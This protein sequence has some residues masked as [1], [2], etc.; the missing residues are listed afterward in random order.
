MACAAVLKWRLT[1]YTIQAETPLS[2][3][4]ATQRM[5]LWS[6]SR[7]I[8]CN[9]FHV[10]SIYD[11]FLELLQQQH[12]TFELIHIIDEVIDSIIKGNPETKKV[13]LITTVA[14]RKTRLFQDK[15]AAKDLTPVDVPA[16]DHELIQ[17]NIWEIKKANAISPK[18]KNSINRNIDY[19]GQEGAEIVIIGCSEIS[20]VFDNNSKTSVP[21]IDPLDT[22]ARATIEKVRYSNS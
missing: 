18:I 19:L 7:A 11:R 1:R 8:P 5:L 13:G 4:P 12:I 22:L 16:K 2:P 3:F 17:E 15:L 21:L 9:T 10:P 14:L 20:M 6:G